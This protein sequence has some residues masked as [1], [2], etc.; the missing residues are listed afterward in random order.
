MAAK[1]KYDNNIRMGNRVR[2]LREEENGEGEVQGT[3]GNFI[4]VQWDGGDEER[5]DGRHVVVADR[6]FGGTRRR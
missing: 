6:R 2:D 4:L 3:D 5:V 1:D